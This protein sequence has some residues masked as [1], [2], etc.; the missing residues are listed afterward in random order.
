MAEDTHPARPAVAPLAFLAVLALALLIP[1]T[2][3]LPLLDRDEP[4]FARATVEMIDRGEWIVPYFNGDYRF[5]KPV[6]TYWLMRGGYALFGVGEAGARAHSVAATLLLAWLVWAMGRHWFSPRAGLYAAAAM[7]FSEQFLVHGR[8]AVADLP[9]VLCVAAAQF[10][11]WRLLSTEDAAARRPWFWALYGALGA[12]FL[13]KGPVAWLVP[14]LTLVLFRF[15]FGRRPMPWARLRAGWG[16]LVVLA[17]LAPWGV[18]ALVKTH[19]AFW[20]TGMGEHVVKRGFE[21][22]D[23]RRFVP[24]FYVPTALLSLFPWIA[25]GGRAWAAARERWDAPRAFLASWLLAP[26]L[27]FSLY[28]TQLPHYVLPAFPAFFLLLGDAADRPPS[29]LPRWDGALRGLVFGIGAL[30]VVAALALALPWDRRLEP[31]LLGLAAFAGGLT[32]A[33][34]LFPRPRAA[35]LALAVA[36]AGGGLWCFGS[37]LRA[38]LPALEI[39]EAMTDLPRGADCAWYRFREPSVVFYTGRPWAAAASPGALASFLSRP[40]PRAALALEEQT[41]LGDD[42]AARLRG[43]AQPARTKRWDDEVAGLRQPGVQLRYIEGLNAARGAWVRLVLA[44]RPAAPEAAASAPSA[45]APGDAGQPPSA[46]PARRD[47]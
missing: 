34:T 29:R 33:G 2:S 36:L 30:I 20:A 39:A 9:M 43:Q 46:G 45:A 4:R 27:I 12:G 44:V 19:G 21:A 23:G 13:A 37:G 17:I 26:Y 8:S 11:L 24:F 14:A 28:S 25:W 41:D 32:L 40:G 15:A 18:P 35:R 47:N 22:F 7:L 5:D 38:V 1:G 42:L 10:A 16:A 6:L 31:M 3:A